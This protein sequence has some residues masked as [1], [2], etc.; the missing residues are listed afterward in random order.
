MLLWG[1]DKLFIDL[2][3][4]FHLYLCNM[5]IYWSFWCLIFLYGFVEIAYFYCILIFIGSLKKSLFIHKIEIHTKKFLFLS[6]CHICLSVLV[7]NHTFMMAKM[8]VAAWDLPPILFGVPV[9]D[10]LLTAWNVK[11]A[12]GGSR[13]CVSLCACMW[14]GYRISNH[15]VRKFKGN[16][17]AFACEIMLHLFDIRLK[18]AE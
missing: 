5:I 10:K 8:V 11:E 18:T 4:I 17:T 12:S 1:S 3:H 6:K 15:R 13:E 9:Q 14:A 16:A 2:G 7:A